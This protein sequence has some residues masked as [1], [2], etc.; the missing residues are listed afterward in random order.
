ME[1]PEAVRLVRH[2]HRLSASNLSGQASKG[3]IS[4]KQND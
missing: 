4:N 1:I 2:I 3:H